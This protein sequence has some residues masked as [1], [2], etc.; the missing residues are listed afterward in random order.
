VSS[1][2][3][4][5]LVDFRGALEAAA[6]RDLTARR[7]RV[8]AGRLALAAVFVGAAAL[9]ALSIVSR[10]TA[11]GSVVDRATAAIARSPGTILHVDML[12]TQTNGDGSVVTWRDESWE[13]QSAPYDGR[14]IETATDGSVAETAT[15]GGRDELY[16]PTRN[17]I[18]V[19]PRVNET[20]Y[21]MNQWDLKPGPRPG[22][23]LLRVGDVQGGHIVATGVITTAQANALRKR[24]DVIAWRVG[25]HGALSP[26]VTVIPASSVPKPP[27]SGNDSAAADPT[28]SGF[29]GQILALLRSGEA[30]V[31][32][33][34]T[35]D[36][37]DTVEIASAD[38]HTSYYVDP[39]T[40]RPVEL[41]TR[42]TDGGVSLRFRTYETL[43]LD[44]NTSLLSL[45]AQ[46][47]GARVD[48]DPAH[49]RA[50]QARIFP[51]G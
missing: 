17:T 15:T 44:A 22:T 32:G 1:T 14:Q 26:G 39:A 48:R 4:T 7:R 24:D 37:R 41:D 11:G 6:H 10:H 18:Y 9:G 8:R 21:E 25:P 49:F 2:L 30:R 50:A 33:H 36:G 23:E 35:I 19:A 46:Y 43:Q 31:I 45:T 20:P 51:R 40:Y 28:A 16:D 3:P 34:R 29:R 27:P 5:S 47:P 12:G 42:G 13:Q 38:G